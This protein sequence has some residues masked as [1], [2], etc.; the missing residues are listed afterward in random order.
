[1]A[2]RLLTMRYLSGKERVACFGERV[3]RRGGRR[4]EKAPRPACLTPSPI[5]PAEVRLHCKSYCGCHQEDSRWVAIGWFR[6]AAV[7]GVEAAARRLLVSPNRTARAA[8][9]NPVDP[10]ERDVLASSWR[11]GAIRKMLS[12][13]HSP[14]VIESRPH[15]SEFEGAVA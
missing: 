11:R 14:L 6:A 3:A 9:R 2:L 15:D 1:M 4:A 8:R 13:T 10:A 12:E 5:S 7:T